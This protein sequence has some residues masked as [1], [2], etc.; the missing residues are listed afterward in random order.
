MAAEVSR[1][2]EWEKWGREHAKPAL[3]HYN[4]FDAPDDSVAAAALAALPAMPTRG[5]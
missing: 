2:R 3:E 5:E 1:L 4:Q